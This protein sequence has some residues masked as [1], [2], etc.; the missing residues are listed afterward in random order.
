MDRIGLPMLGKETMSLISVVSSLY[1][2]IFEVTTT[3]HLSVHSNAAIIGK[4][5]LALLNHNLN[6]HVH[7]YM[8]SNHGKISH[9]QVHFKLS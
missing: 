4:T 9:R 6:Q 8:N 3:S 7:Y 5:V 1:L 2:Q